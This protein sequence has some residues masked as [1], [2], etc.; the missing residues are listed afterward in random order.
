M[1]LWSDNDINPVTDLCRSHAWSRH[2]KTLSAGGGEESKSPDNVAED[3]SVRNSYNLPPIPS[4]RT[5]KKSKDIKYQNTEKILQELRSEVIEKDCEIAFL[6][7]ERSK[8]KEI[9]RTE[10]AEIQDIKTVLSK[11]AAFNSSSSNE[12]NPN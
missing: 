5:K 6:K 11:L 7:Q 10:M 1:K 4:P 8:M 12:E 2:S 3:I 9:V